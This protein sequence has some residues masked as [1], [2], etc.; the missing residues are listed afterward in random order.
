MVDQD[1][2]IVGL[3]LT[4]DRLRWGIGAPGDR[5]GEPLVPDDVAPAVTGGQV[6]LLR[7]LDAGGEPLVDATGAAVTAGSWTAALSSFSVARAAFL[8]DIVRRHDAWR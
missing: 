6:D 3:L 7:V 1:Q 8:D 4:R 5:A 2:L